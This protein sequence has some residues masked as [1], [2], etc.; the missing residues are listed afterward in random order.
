MWNWIATRPLRV[1]S[2]QNWWKED[3]R[4]MRRN[5]N[6]AKETLT[7]TLNSS[8]RADVRRVRD[9]RRTRKWNVALAWPL[10]KTSW[11]WRL[12]LQ[13]TGKVVAEL[14]HPP[15]TTI[16]TVTRSWIVAVGLYPKPTLRRTGRV[17]FTSDLRWGTRRRPGHSSW[18][19][20]RRYKGDRCL[21]SASLWQTQTIIST[22]EF[23]IFAFFSLKLIINIR[24]FYYY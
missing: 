3:R 4:R 6:C 10:L 13:E 16:R 8:F 18:R 22:F 23:Q 17:R 9:A 14:F 24:I 20:L 7:Y 15:N 19:R 12:G 11:L 1:E 5:G 2:R 21:S